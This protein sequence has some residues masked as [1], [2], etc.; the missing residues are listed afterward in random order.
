M[1][2]LKIVVLK[3]SIKD[4]TQSLRNHYLCFL[5]RFRVDAVVGIQMSKCHMFICREKE[6]VRVPIKIQFAVIWQLCSAG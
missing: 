6:S 4:S 1:N 5:L 2:F 3:K